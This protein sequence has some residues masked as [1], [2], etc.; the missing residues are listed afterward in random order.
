MSAR[1]ETA[2]MPSSRHRFVDRATELR[3][4]RRDG[5]NAL[6]WR[7]PGSEELLQARARAL[8]AQEPGLKL[9]LQGRPDEIRTGLLEEVGPRPFDIHRLARD[10]EHLAQN[11]AVVA[12]SVILRAQLEVVENQPCHLFHV[13]KLQLRM[14]CT[15]VGAG[16]EY[17]D[18]CHAERSR[19]GRG[20]NEG[21]LAGH[22]PL[23]IEPNHVILMKGERFPG[24]TG[25][26]AIH[27]SPEQGPTEPRLVLRL[28]HA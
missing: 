18:D 27:R 14:L 28:D 6:I 21:V 1:P 16:T 20:D 13:D 8:M 7:R 22:S 5:V 10:V 15:Y 2:A 3:G 19:L 24:V 23:Q 17:V 26:G 11:L 9:D 4:I 12:R 25:A